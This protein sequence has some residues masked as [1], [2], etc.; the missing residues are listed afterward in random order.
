MRIEWFGGEPTL[1]LGT[2]EEFS[3]FFLDF[4][5]AH[6]IAYEAVAL[7]NC[8]MVDVAAARL[9]SDC[10][11]KKVAVSFA[12]ERE[13]HDERR[14]MAGAGSAFDRCLEALRALLRAGRLRVPEI[15]VTP[16][17]RGRRVPLL[18]YAICST[19]PRV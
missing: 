15:R 13:L 7:S 9:L 12:G 19:K 3:G 5:E 11:V 6:G 18:T 16:A 17:A 14:Q 2:I 8:T 1:A 10:G 4:C